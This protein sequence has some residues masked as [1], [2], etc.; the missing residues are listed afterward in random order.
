MSLVVR[1]NPTGLTKA[2][3]DSTIE[4]IKAA[5]QFP[6]DGLDYH[7]CFGTE[8]DLKVSEIWDSQAQLDEFGVRLMPI[9]SAEGIVM[10]E[11]PDVFEVHNLIRR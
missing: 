11:P 4:K 1:F 7:I 6:P 9:L 10:T 8:G 2:K 5:G 3:Y